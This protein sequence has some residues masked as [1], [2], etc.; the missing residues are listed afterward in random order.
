M[1]FK[2]STWKK[3]KANAI[4]DELQASRDGQVKSTLIIDG[5]EDSGNPLID[6]FWAYFGGKPKQIKDEEEEKKVPDYT[7]SLHHISDASG[8]METNEVCSGQL[9]K[10]KLDNN[11]AFIL[12]AGGSLFV[13]IGKGTNKADKREVI[14]F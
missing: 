11:D 7:L 5:V 8:V 14:S 13:W 2:S 6:D 12:D 3:R 4:L 9:D 10:S 1:F